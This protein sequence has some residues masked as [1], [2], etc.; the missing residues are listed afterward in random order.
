[1]PVAQFTLTAYQAK[2]LIAHCVQRSG[3]LDPYLREGRI[4]FKGSTTV[5]CLSRL[6]A[7]RPM[8]ICGR[9]TRGG[10]KSFK[11]QTDGPHWLLYEKGE[12][13][14][15]DEHVMDIIQTFTKRDLFI[16]GANAID[17]FGHAALLIGSPGGGGY[18]LCLG[19]CYTEGFRT[20]VLTTSSKLVPGDLSALYAQ[21]SRTGCDYAYGMACGLIPVPGEIVTEERAIRQYADVDALIFA[22]GGHTGA[23][24]VT[25]IQISGP[26]EEVEKVLALVD[27]VRA[28][29]G[30]LGDPVSEVECTY[31]SMGCG[32]HLSC[33]HAKKNT[34]HKT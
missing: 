17:A 27:E 24:D 6:V 15:V 30:P 10:M 28:I 20:L 31:P 1:M 2:W 21:V 16:T 29:Q 32:Y 7:D 23:E 18:G 26:E 25:A 22:K 9:V 34:I 8:R 33:C 4:L 11:T 3:M 12:A 13:T 5:S 14:V 19:A